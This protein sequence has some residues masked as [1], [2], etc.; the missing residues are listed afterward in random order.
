MFF[1]GNVIENVVCKFWPSCS[2]INMFIMD[3]VAGF[4]SIPRI[5]GCCPLI[6]LF[7][8]LYGSWSMGL[9]YLFLCYFAEHILHVFQVKL[10]KSSLRQNV[11]FVE[12]NIFKFIFLN[13]N[14]FYMI[15]ISLKFAPN[16]SLNNK[17]SLVQIII[18]SFVLN[19]HLN[20][21]WPSLLML[22][23][24]VKKIRLSCYLILLSND[25][26]TR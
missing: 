12:T 22:M 26:K 25:S 9:C 23:S 4:R 13:E 14:N 7:I 3:D 24:R 19:R 5:G 8:A 20:Q 16:G 11:P 10:N 15:Q 2:L 18:P 21:W 6:D 17:S 1:Q